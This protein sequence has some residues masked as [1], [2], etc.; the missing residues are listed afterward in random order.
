MYR[1]VRTLKPYSDYPTRKKIRKL[2][3]SS[4]F[5]F[6]LMLITIE[7]CREQLFDFSIESNWETVKVIQFHYTPDFFNS[8]LRNAFGCRK[9]EIVKKSFNTPTESA[10]GTFDIIVTDYKPWS[11][12]NNFRAIVMLSEDPWFLPTPQ[13]DDRVTF[14][15][16][17]KGINGTS[18]FP[19]YV[20]S[21]GI[22]K[23]NRPKDLIK[24]EKDVA[25]AAGTKT[26]FC[27][28]MYTH[29]SQPRDRIFE[30]LSLYKPVTILGSWNPSTR[31]KENLKNFDRKLYNNRVTYF[32]T[33]VEKYKPY[34]FVI[35]GENTEGLTG[36]IT[37]K[38]VNAMLSGAIPIY[39]GA[40]DIK[41][42]I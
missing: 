39:I 24:T 9:L 16:A 21:F 27:A 31:K 6:I 35:A 33:A 1:G 28:F 14:I 34:K 3:N 42:N 12:V 22:R 17:V 38:I 32:D 19:F 25:M 15:H 30:I 36:Y 11:K 7:I 23:K 10:N 2:L 13:F 18:Y 5:R 26:E 29:E 4:Y 41:G 37:E 20:S 8:G 40:P